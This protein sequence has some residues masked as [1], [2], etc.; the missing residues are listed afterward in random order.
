MEKRALIVILVVTALIGGA[1]WFM[2]SQGSTSRIP[3]NGRLR[4]VTTFLPIYVFT[5]NVAGDYADVEN[6]LPPGVGPHDYAFTPGDFRKVASADVIVAN[7]LGLESWMTDLISSSGAKAKLIEAG[8][9]IVTTDFGD[10]TTVAGGASSGE[11]V[12][13]NPHVWLDPVLAK[14]EVAN[15]AE[16]LARS[17]SSHAAGY[18][19]NAAEYSKKLEALDAEYRTALAGLANKDFVSFHPAF[20]YLA[21]RYGLNGLAVVEEFPGKEPGAKYLASLVDLIKARQVQ[22][23]F[24]EPQFS[25]KIVETVAAETGARVYALDTGEVGDLSADSYI[26]IMEENLKVLV[27]AF[28]S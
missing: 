20:D 10:T 12:G 8:K 26:K 11:D 21:S 24:S 5:K 25:P 16:A 6:L 14:T 4:I 27:R 15:I 3:S 9:G 13:V 18:R 28:S 7:G 1:V 23:L 22:V 2:V 17:D 19:R